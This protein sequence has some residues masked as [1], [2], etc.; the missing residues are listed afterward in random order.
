M[1]AMGCMCEVCV[2][3]ERNIFVLCNFN[4]EELLPVGSTFISNYILLI[5]INRQTLY[6]S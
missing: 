6:L 5:S 1:Y 3:G 4:L 2:L